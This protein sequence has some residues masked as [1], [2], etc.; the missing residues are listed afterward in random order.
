MRRIVEE[1]LREA[2]ALLAA[3]RS[4]LDALAQALIRE[5]SLGESEIL[6]VTGL[7]PQPQAVGAAATVGSSQSNA[8]D[9]AGEKKSEA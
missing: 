8:P 3:H 1:C 4:K 6:E 5:E 2:Q 9:G 7:K